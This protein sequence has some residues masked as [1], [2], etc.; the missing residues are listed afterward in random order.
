[1]FKTTTLLFLSSVTCFYAQQSITHVDDNTVLS[2]GNNALLYNSGSFE[3]EGAGKSEIFGNLMLESTSA[4]D[5]FKTINGNNE[6]FFLRI[7]DKSD[8]KNSTFGQL[9]IK[10]ISQD[11]ITA[12]V[13][14]E[15]AT[16]KHGDYQQIGIPFFDKQF[17]S[18]S[19]EFNAEFN[20]SRWTKKEILRWNNNFARFDGSVIPTSQITS[21][22]TPNIS[23]NLADKTNITNRA[24]YYAIGTLG[25]F[26][27]ENL[28]VLKGRP[29]TDNLK[30]ALNQPTINFGTG[31][32]GTN[33]YREKFNTYLSD[34]FEVDN[35]WQQTFGKYIYQFSNP[36]FTNIDLSLIG[37]D[38]TLYGASVGDNNNIT[39]IWGISINPNDVKFNVNTGTTSVYSSNQIIT[40]DS[41]NRPVGNVEALIVKPLGTF[42]IKL[43]NDTPAEL[44]FDNIRRFSSTPRSES[45]DYSV[46]ASKGSFSGSI[47][48]L[49]ILLLD[50]S[51]QV[52]GETYYAVAPHFQTGNID[53]PHLKSV[54]AV[55]TPANLISTY[56]EN[57]SGGI[58]PNFSSKY[59]LYINE[60]NEENFEGKQINLSVYSGSFLK[61]QI[62]ENSHLTNTLTS[63]KSFYYKNENGALTEIKQGDI[64]PV[65]GNNYVILYGKPNG[66]LDVI[67]SKPNRTVI[68]YNNLIQSNVIV[69]DPN[70]KTADIK[71]YDMS[72][73]MV[74]NQNNV[75]TKNIFVLDVDKNQ[76]TP[77]VINIVS[78][79]GDI[80]NTKFLNR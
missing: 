64:I 40:F 2:V 41:N 74:L 49:G 6:N 19:S 32:N 22:S 18:L 45:T 59:R 58:D 28:S 54:Q 20:N 47:K 77:F 46:T 30:I 71:V 65:D 42:K 76:R 69:F 43:R 79:K 3:T 9:Y 55:A 11:A 26:N 38:E 78:D 73:K 15:F 67:T 4:D 37:I 52:I 57:L 36:F 48:Q 72:G 24:S 31:G 17:L 51:K 27:T 23:I 10:G 80:V 62:R 7:N 13:N 29:F 63:G 75:N 21:N 56:E 25:A 1:M 16:T 39:N 14:K 44:D 12:I 8:S 5:T 35:P 50:E 33:V 53:L 70:W 61:F 34:I 66:Y 68:T 60:A